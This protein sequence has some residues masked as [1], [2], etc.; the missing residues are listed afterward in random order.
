MMVN[1]RTN[2]RQGRHPTRNRAA[3]TVGELV[4]AS[5]F[6]PPGGGVTLAASLPG[7]LLFLLLATGDIAGQIDVTRLPGIR[8]HAPRSPVLDATAPP[9]PEF[10]TEITN[11]DSHAIR[12]GIIASVGGGIVLLIIGKMFKRE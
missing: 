4:R 7:A 2:R 11:E 3:A 8:R 6:L 5:L 1:R 9:H 10:H 12:N